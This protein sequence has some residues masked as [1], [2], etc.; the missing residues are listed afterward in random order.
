MQIQAEFF[1]SIFKI[2]YCFQIDVGINSQFM[3]VPDIYGSYHI[4]LKPLI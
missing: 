1:F 3:P 2:Q 4:L